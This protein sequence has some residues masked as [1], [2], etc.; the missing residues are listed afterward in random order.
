MFDP[1]ISLDIQERLF[2]K[3]SGSLERNQIQKSVIYFEKY[4][5]NLTQTL[6]NTAV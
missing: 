3:F 4:Y 1:G 6:K 5:A 2:R